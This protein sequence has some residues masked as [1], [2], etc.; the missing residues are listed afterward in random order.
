M[1]YSTQ[2]LFPQSF[3]ETYNAQL[4][5]NSHCVGVNRLTKFTQNIMTRQ[6]K[7]L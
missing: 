5:L 7:H 4:N 2:E 6:K 3:V 1:C